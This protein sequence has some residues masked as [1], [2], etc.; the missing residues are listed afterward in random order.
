MRQLTKQYI[1]TW[2][3]NNVKFNYKKLRHIIFKKKDGVGKT[4]CRPPPSSDLTGGHPVT[5]EVV[6]GRVLAASCLYLLP[7][8]F[9]LLN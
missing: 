3:K 9:F 7:L 8:L 2:H 5:G 6:G 1:S 4:V